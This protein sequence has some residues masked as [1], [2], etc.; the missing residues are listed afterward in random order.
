MKL[1]SELVDA[2]AALVNGNTEKSADVNAYGTASM[3]D[4]KT[5]VKMDG[6]DLLVPASTTVKVSDNERVRILIQNHEVTIVGNLTEPS[7]GATVV[8]GPKG[9]K[10]DPGEPG[11]KGD[12]GD[13]GNSIDTNGFVKNVGDT[14]FSMMQADHAYIHE[15]VDTTVPELPVVS[16]YTHIIATNDAGAVVGAMSFGIDM[17]SNVYVYLSGSWHKVSDGGNASSVGKYTESMLSCLS[18]PNILM[19]PNF[20]INQRGKSEY[21]CASG[22]TMTYTVD[23]WYTSSRYITVTSASTG[24]RVAINDSITTATH[25][26]W[27]I[28]ESPLPPGAYVLTAN[29]KHT[30]GNWA[31]RVR[32]VDSSGNYKDSYYTQVLQIGLNK[33]AVVIPDN[34]YIQAVSL[35]ISSSGAAA[36]D[37]ILIEWVKLENGIIATP[38]VPPDPATELLRC[39]RYYQRIPAFLPVR[40]SGVS[41]NFIDFTFPIS[42]PMRTSPSANL[43]DLSICN[44]NYVEQDGFTPSVH[45][46]SSGCICIRAAKTAHGMQDAIAR[47][48][49]AFELSAEL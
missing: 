4:G 45:I 42:V 9:D 14:H 2:F 20:A 43:T 18:N 16:N 47:A 19:N 11:P 35:G 37:Q 7:G 41:A 39:Q 27:Q 36:N 49:S 1:T 24:I 26:L 34:E 12:K 29:V 17:T 40:A 23:R 13:P 5:Y 33:L 32:T 28:L 8:Q 30:V 48:K 25:L 38:F 15:H 21:T 10:G 22:V 3:V 6:S 44:I 31:F 46:V